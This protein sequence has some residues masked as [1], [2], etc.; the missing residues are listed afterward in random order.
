MQAH[1]HGD[2]IRSMGRASSTPRRKLLILGDAALFERVEA[3][4]LA[5][6]DL[7]LAPMLGDAQRVL[8]AH[9]ELTLL[10]VSAHAA[11]AGILRAIKAGYPHLQ[12]VMLTSDDALA[13]EAR[14]LELGD[15]KWLL[16]EDAAPR[17]LC[18]AIQGAFEHSERR[19]AAPQYPVPSAASGVGEVRDAVTPWPHEAGAEIDLQTDWMH[20]VA[21]DLR[22]PLG[23]AGSYA[24]L[25][26]GEGYDLS[27]E[28]REIV[29]RIRTGGE[30]M[31]NLVDRMLELAALREGRPRLKHE[32][33]VLNALLEG[34]VEHLRG[35]AE[36][37][38]VRL[39]RA[40][41]RDSKPYGLDRTRVEQVLHNL[42]INAIRVSPPGG[43][44]RIGAH[45]HKGK[46]CFRVRDQGPGL[47]CEEAAQAFVKFGSSDGGRGLGLAI[48]KAIVRLHGGN[49]WVESEPGQ[50]AEFCFTM[51]PAA[52][53]AR[54][55]S[56]ATPRRTRT[57][58]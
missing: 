39:E 29:Q 26:L 3:A 27:P 57:R 2:D 19:R 44:V 54:G 18:E 41:S 12:A 43:T 15:L 42:V 4:G 1:G 35:Q 28:V 36:V 10:L 34:V 17:Q 50:G 52:V 48:C 30:W 40:R 25:L 13:R 21:H 8:L 56:A 5:H 58:K 14:G 16:A 22:T 32:P 38:G 23:I 45:A 47:T 46:L 37:K 20:V 49:I 51:K 9:P 33:V 53:Q 31:L 11:A 55:R 7:F 6:C 24:D